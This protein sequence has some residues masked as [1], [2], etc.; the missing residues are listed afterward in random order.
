MRFLWYDFEIG[1][2]NVCDIAN[3]RLFLQN[4]EENDTILLPIL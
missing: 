3:M 2:K 1:V 4:G